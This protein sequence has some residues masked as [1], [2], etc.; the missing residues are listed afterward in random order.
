LAYFVRCRKKEKGVL[1]QEREKKVFGGNS[2]VS[3]YILGAI[4]KMKKGF[5]FFFLF[6]LASLMMGVE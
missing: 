3:S 2:T 5:V 1:G 6:F 4:N